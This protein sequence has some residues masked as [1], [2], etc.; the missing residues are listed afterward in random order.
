MNEIF[1]E[2]EEIKL[3]FLIIYIETP[4]LPFGGKNDYGKTV[5]QHEQGW[6]VTVLPRLTDEFQPWVHPWFDSF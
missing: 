3:T 2:N 1:K 5:A 4:I 6:E